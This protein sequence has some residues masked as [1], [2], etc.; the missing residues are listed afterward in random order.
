MRLTESQRQGI[1]VLLHKGGDKPV[2]DAASYR[3]I[4]LLN[5]DVKLLARVLVGRMAAGLDLVVDATQ[6]AFIP[7]RWIGDNVLF[8]LEEID[9]CQAEQ[10]PA[11]VVFLDFEK[12]YD[13][14]DRR[15][16]F[17]GTKLV[18]SAHSK[19]PGAASQPSSRRKGP[20]WPYQD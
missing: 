18:T 13:R 17:F 15:F 16:F 11:C 14:L 4:T 10:V 7:G 2:D 5:T 19:P 6:T 20:P 9:Y 12:A 8:H 1:I 3:P